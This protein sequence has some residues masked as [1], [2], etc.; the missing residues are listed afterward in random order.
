MAL[1]TCRPASIERLTRRAAWWSVAY[2]IFLPAASSV[3]NS[4]RGLT[5]GEQ[6][7]LGG[8]R[9]QIEAQPAVFV[10]LAQAGI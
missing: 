1:L 7:R 5:A 8:N 6:A 9:F 2:R 3:E 10:I 4:P